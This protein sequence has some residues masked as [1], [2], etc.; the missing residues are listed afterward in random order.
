MIGT[1]VGACIALYVGYHQYVKPV[2][3]TIDTV[4][5]AQE[6]GESVN[7]TSNADQACLLGL[8]NDPNKPAPNEQEQIAACYKRGGLYLEQAKAGGNL[9]NE[10]S[11]YSDLFEP[12][13][14]K[15]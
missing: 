4:S 12:F 3:E 5:A 6:F 14:Q 9:V 15:R 13:F 1:V 2:Q 7:R 10:L 11:P 8:G